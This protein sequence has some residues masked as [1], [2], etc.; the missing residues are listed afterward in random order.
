MS[1][2][3]PARPPIAPKIHH[4]P[5]ELTSDEA[6]VIYTVGRERHGTCIYS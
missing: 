3:A 2:A 4:T 5:L 1:A 6:V